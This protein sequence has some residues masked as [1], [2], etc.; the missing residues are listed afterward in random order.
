MKPAKQTW[1]LYYTEKTRSLG[2]KNKRVHSMEKQS[3]GIYDAGK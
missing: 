1:A 3:V 2:Y